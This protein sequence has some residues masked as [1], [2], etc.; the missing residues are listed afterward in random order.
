[1]C[2]VRG[3]IFYPEKIF[4]T[5][6][7][8]MA[9]TY[10]IPEVSSI[11]AINS[12]NLDITSGSWP[13]LQVH[14]V[15]RPRKLSSLGLGF[16][17]S[18]H[19]P[20]YDLVCLNTMTHLY[21]W[22]CP[23]PGPLSWAPWW[24]GPTPGSWGSSPRPGW[25]SSHSTAGT[26]I[27][28]YTVILSYSDHAPLVSCQTV[29]KSSLWLLAACPTWPPLWSELRTMASHGTSWSQLSFSTSPTTTC[30]HSNHLHHHHHHHYYLLTL[31]AHQPLPPDDGHL[32]VVRSLVLLV[33]AKFLLDNVKKLC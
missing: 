10:I 25:R 3:I 19:R 4:V 33:P 5:F 16:S 8:K 2:N 31:H 13:S 14:T 21:S 1:M 17:H 11:L 24:G 32:P 30:Q 29:S 23:L 18:T 27:V 26:W 15:R 9:E 6:L 22:T 12:I 7:G 20:G 28:S